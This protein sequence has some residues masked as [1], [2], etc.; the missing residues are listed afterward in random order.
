MMRA[1]DEP[2]LQSLLLCVVRHVCLRWNV[3]LNSLVVCHMFDDCVTDFF[4]LNAH[5]MMQP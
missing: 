2:L 1:R 4:V 3:S 5:C